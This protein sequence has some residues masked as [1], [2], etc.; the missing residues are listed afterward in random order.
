MKTNKLICAKQLHLAKCKHSINSTV[1]IIID[2][3][4]LAIW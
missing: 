2:F 1:V 3:K 4:V